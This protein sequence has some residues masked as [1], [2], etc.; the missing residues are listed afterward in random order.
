VLPTGGTTGQLLVKVSETDYDTAWV[1]YPTPP[2]ATTSDVSGTVNLDM[3]SVNGTYQTFNLID[4]VTFTTTNLQAGYTVTV[5][6]VSG[7]TQ[8]DL[9]FPNDW[10]FVGEEPLS[11]AANKTGILAV[12]SFG[13]T[14][15]AC[16]AAWAVQP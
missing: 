16:V 6:I 11:I 1:N 10:V 8:C 9:V 14:D 12:T 2:V 5:R 7:A 15:S 3:A 13:T 4:D